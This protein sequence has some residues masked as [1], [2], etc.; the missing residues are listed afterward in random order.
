M[1][2][3]P[4]GWRL[5]LIALLGATGVMAGAFAAHGLRGRVPDAQ[6]LIWETA[7]DYQLYTRLSCWHCWGCATILLRVPA[8]AGWEQLRV[9]LS[10][11]SWFSLAPFTC[12]C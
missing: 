3:N 7:A 6:L 5:W 8:S 10:G 1:P 12:W 9:Y 11:A 2:A 4:L